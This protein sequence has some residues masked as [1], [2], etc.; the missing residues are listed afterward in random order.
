[1]IKPKGAEGKYKM[2][3]IDSHIPKRSKQV[4][5]SDKQGALCKKRGGHYKLHNTHDYHK[6]DPDSTPIKRNGAQVAHEGTD[7]T[8]RTVE[9]REITKGQ[10]MLS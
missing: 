9:T 1:M 10:I 3:S 7:I 8:T 6:F 2:E 4:G 5:F